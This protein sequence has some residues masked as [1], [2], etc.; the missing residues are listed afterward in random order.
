MGERHGSRGDGR[1]VRNLKREE[2][3][4]LVVDVF[5]GILELRRRK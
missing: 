5:I 4:R 2:E 3:G 1:G